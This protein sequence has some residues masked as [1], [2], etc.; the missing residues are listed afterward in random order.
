MAEQ[1]TSDAPVEK[2]APPV[3]LTAEELDTVA[4]GVSVV[5]RRLANPDLPAGNGNAQGI[6]A[7]LIGL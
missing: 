7:I 6:I 4:G 3:E 5:L 2:P 1:R